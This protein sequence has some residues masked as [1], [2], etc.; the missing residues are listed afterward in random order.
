MK[1]LR[2]L[3]IR[4]FFTP[5]KVEIQLQMLF[6]NPD[7]EHISLEDEVFKTQEHISREFVKPILA[8]DFLSS[9]V[10]YPNNKVFDLDTWALRTQTNCGRK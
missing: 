9:F 7:N 4:E 1:N 8:L 10:K 6:N 2:Y 5:L 3:T